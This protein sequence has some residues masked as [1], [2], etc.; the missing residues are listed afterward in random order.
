[1]PVLIQQNAYVIKMDNEQNHCTGEFDD[2]HLQWIEFHRTQ[3]GQEM[4][5]S[6]CST[7]LDIHQ[8]VQQCES[9]KNKHNMLKIS[10][11]KSSEK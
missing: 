4:R 7:V 11:V 6:I 9:V 3:Q 1:M 10:M 5:Y 8:L 2:I